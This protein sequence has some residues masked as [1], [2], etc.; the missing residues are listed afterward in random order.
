MLSEQE[1]IRRDSLQ[2]IIDYGIN[3]YPAAEFKVSHYS[4]DILEN[5]KEG[6]NVIIAGRLMRRKIQGKASFGSIQ[7]SKGK[8][9]VYF[10]RDVICPSEDKSM[11]NDFFK[12]WLDLGDI[13]GIEGKVF[14][15]MVGEISISVDKFHLL[16]KSLKPLPQPKSKTRSWSRS[17][18]C[19]YYGTSPIWVSCLKALPIPNKKPRH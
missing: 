12:K 10:N 2:K 11:Y 14:K 18:R 15:T 16:S 6:E 3:P 17:K 4:I 9:Q 1:Q 8:I 7:D 19:R 13:L 5:F